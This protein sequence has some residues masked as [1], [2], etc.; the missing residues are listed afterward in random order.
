MLR[1]FRDRKDAGQQLAR[2]VLYLRAERPVVIAL[3]RGGAAVGLEV[4]RALR[5]PLDLAIPRKIGHPLHPE[6][7]VAAVTEAGELVFGETIDAASPPD[8]LDQ[9]RQ[10]EQHEAA[11]RRELYMM[12]REHLP[13]E[14][15]TAVIVDDG[16]A[17]GLT[18]EAAIREVRQRGAQKV[19]VAVP[20]GPHEVLEE[21]K[22]QADEVA[23]VLS[24]RRFLG[25]VGAYYEQFGQTSDREVVAALAEAGRNDEETRAWKS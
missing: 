21:L 6:F 5:A 1:M 22:E 19:V 2:E 15:R 4:A 17:T 13:L 23:P 9:E 3:P 12:G 8:W 10:D 14:G 11:R 20:V 7:A 24:A 25:S 16:I 18:M